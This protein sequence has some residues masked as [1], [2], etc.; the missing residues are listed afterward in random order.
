M[1]RDPRLDPQP[2]DRSDVWTSSP[3]FRTMLDES[4]ADI[5]AGRYARF[6]TIDDLLADLD[7]NKAEVVKEE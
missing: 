6:S 7:G 1:P 4:R 3:A 5:A 2:G